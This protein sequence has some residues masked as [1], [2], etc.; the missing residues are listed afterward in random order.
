MD[1]QSFRFCLLIPCYNDS[2]GLI[3]SLK[4]VEYDKERFIALVV[5]DGSNIPLKTWE[6]K[7]Q[8]GSQYPLVVVRN[9]ENKGITYSL[10]KGLEWIEKNVQV[11]YIARLDCNDIC[12]NDR[13]NKQVTFLDEHPDVALIGSWCVFE[14]KSSLKYNYVTPTGHEGILRAMYMRNVFIHPTTMWRMSRLSDVGSYPDQYPHAEDYAFFWEFLRIG[15]G[16]IMP[17][18]LVLCE[19]N[20]EGISLRNR[21]QQLFSRLKVVKHYGTN[22]VLKAAGIFKIYALRLIPKRL[23][24]QLKHRKGGQ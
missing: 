3:Q 13:F 23:V 9:E 17:E 16:Y 8:L 22:P 19:I 12:T 15:K 18:F 21:Q 5:D 1:R 7:E 2:K 14:S 11:E 20:S 6:L 4:T 24:L 10:N